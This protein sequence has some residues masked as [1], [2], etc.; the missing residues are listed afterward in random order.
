MDSLKPIHIPTILELLMQGAKDRPVEVSTISLAKQIGRSQQAAS[1]HLLE[2][3]SE[4]FI[5]RVRM[6]HRSGVKLTSKGVDAVMKLYAQL[7]GALE[8]MPPVMEIKG[9][10][11]SGIGEGAYYVSLHGYRRQFLKRL[12]FDPYPGTLNL[13]L[14]TSMDRRLRRDLEQYRGIYIEGF[15]DEHR[16][17]GGVWCFHAVINDTFEGALLITERTHYDDSVLEIIAPISIREKLRLK[18]G[19]EVR[20]RI[21]I[22]TA[23]PP[24]TG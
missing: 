3:E 19:D 4:G 21:Y 9:E 24:T 5:E 17:Y 10:L 13:K 15:Q 14:K 2:L 16:T 22:P 23:W 6:G 11:F 20:V 12:G 8:E 1:K 18:D 7:R